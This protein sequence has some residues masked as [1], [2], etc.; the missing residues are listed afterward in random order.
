MRASKIKIKKGKTTITTDWELEK[1]DCNSKEEFLWIYVLDGCG[2]GSANELQKLAWKVFELFA[3]HHKERK[4]SIYDD[5]KTEIIAHWLNSKGLLEHGTSIGGSWLSEKG[6]CLYKEL[7]EWFNKSKIH[8]CIK[9]NKPTNTKHKFSE[10]SKGFYCE[11]Y[12]CDEC[13]EE[14]KE[15]NR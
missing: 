13:Y 8:H 15:E 9:C 10:D 14:I 5:K 1:Y 4:W 7:N 12:C 3:T 11:E 6:E 2:C